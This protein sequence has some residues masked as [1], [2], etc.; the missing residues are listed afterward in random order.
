MKEETLQVVPRN[1]KDHKRILLRA[2]K[3]GDLED[4]L[5]HLYS[6]IDYL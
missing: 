3:I 5:I 6:F 2:N 1:T 4:V